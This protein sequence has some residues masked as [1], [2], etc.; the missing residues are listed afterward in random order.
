MTS[1]IGTKKISSSK[2]GFGSDKYEDTHKQNMDKD[3]RKYFLPEFLNRIDE[4]IFF[5]SLNENDLFEIIDL[6]LN[7]LKNNLSEKNNSLRVSK[8]AK[9]YLLRDGAHRE[10]GARPLRRLI[11][12]EIENRISNGFIKG[13]FKDCKGLITIKSKNNKLVFKQFR[14]K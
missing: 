9:E 4:I 7:D 1:N 11:Q 5:N 10:W 3:V 6:Q 13:L 8:T 12:N 14:K 2:I